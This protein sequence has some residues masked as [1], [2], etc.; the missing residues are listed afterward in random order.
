MIDPGSNGMSDIWEY[1][2]AGSTN[3]PPDVDSDGDGASNQHESIAGTNPL[4]ANS[5]PKIATGFYSGPRFSVTFPA[6]NGVQYQLQSLTSLGATNWLMETG[7]VATGSSMTLLGAADTDSK[8]FRVAV[9]GAGPGS[10]SPPQI[11]VFSHRGPSFTATMSGVAGKYYELQSVASLSSTNWLMETGTVA[12]VDATL[13]LSAS[14]LPGEKFFR[15]AISDMDSDLDGASD[16]EERQIGTDPFAA[17]STGQLDVNGQ[18]L[19][20]SAYALSKLASQN[21]VTIYASE[22]EATQPDAGQTATDLGNFT[23]VRGGLPLNAVTVNLGINGPAPGVAVEGVDHAVLLRPV[24][25]AAGSAAAN[26]QVVPLAHTN[27]LSP[28]VATMKVMGGSGYSV[29]VFSNANVVIYPSPTPTGTGLTA[30]Y[31]DNASS[32]YTNAANFSGT[33]VTQLDPKIDFQ[34]S[35]TT[36]PTPGIATNTYSIRWMGQVQPQYSEPYV[37]IVRT[38]DGSKLWVNDQ[39]IHDDWRNKGASDV[40]SSEITLQAGVRY[41]LKLEYYQNT[42][43]AEARLYWYS[44][45]Q[46]KQIIP[47]ARLY[48]DSVTPAPTAVTS[49]LKLY[50]FLGQPFSNNV[51]AANSPLGYAATGLPPGLGFNSTNGAI[52]GVPA[53]TG[54]FSVSLTASNAVGVGA[55]VVEIDVIEAGSAVSREVWLGVSGTNVADIPVNTPP[56]S[57]EAWGALEGVTD[58]GDNYGER[59]RG[60]LTAPATGNYHFWIAGSDAAELWISND[61]EACNKVRRAWVTPGGTGSQQWNLQAKQ[62]SPWLAMVAGQRYYIEILH[63]AGASTGDNW[64]V[65]WLFDPTGTNSSPSG[66]VPS[67]VLSRHFDVPPAFVPGTLYTANLLAQPG[68][69]SSGVGTAT[70]RVSADETHAVLKYNYSGLSGPITSQ[71]IHSDPYL[72]FPSTILFDIDDAEPEP[73]GSL[74]WLIEP[75]GAL[76]ADDIR[77]IIKEGKTYINL[78]TAAYPAGEIKGNFTLAEGS[79]SF[80]PPPA[81]PA[82]ADDHANASAAARFLIQATFGSTA[83]DIASVQSLG[84]EGW[85]DNQFAMPVTHHLPIVHANVGPDPT[86]PYSGNLTFN[87]WWQQSITAP[88]Q[89]RQRVAFALSEIL[90]VSEQGVLNNRG[91]A[92][93][94]YYDTLLEHSFGNFRDLLE[95]VTLHP[96]MGLYLDMRR[97]D[98]GNILTGT[99]PNENYAREILQ[100]FSIGLY[101]QWPDGTLVMNSEGN[102]VPTYG[103]DEILGF[104]R[105][106]TGWNYYQT[107]Q[108][109]GRLPS[110]WNPSANYTNLMVLVPTHHELGTKLVLDNVVLPQAWGDE[111]DSGSTN[112]DNYG[113]RD[114]ELSHDSIFN[115]ENVGPFIC[116]QLIQRLVT[117]HPTRDYVYRVVQ[118][119]NDNGNGVRGDMQAVIKAILLDYQARSSAAALQPAFGKQ[120][121]PL[122][123]VTAPARAFATPPPVSGTY[124]QTGTQTISVTTGSPHRMNNND[125]P[126]C[127]FTDTSGH[128]APP[129]QRY[130]NVSVTGLNTFNTTAPGL[131]VGTY[132]QSANTITVIN[133]GHA[134]A[135]GNSVHLTFTSGGASNGA[136]VVQSVPSTTNFTVTAADS[137]TRSGSC[138]FPKWTGGG[139]VQ[140]A[141]NVTFSL[142]LEHGLTVGDS[143]YVNF[144]QANAP[145]DGIY[146]VTATNDPI[147]FSIVVTNSANRTQ[148]GQTIFPLVQTLLNRSGNVEV[149][150]NTWQMNAT[151]TGT[152]LSLSQTP[153]NSP[154]VF[155]YYF[156]DYKFPGILASAGL[157][158][159]EFQLTSDTE[160]MLQMNFMTLG[161][162]GNTGN[163][164]GLSSFN[165]GNGAI[166]LDL[167][168]WMTPAYTSNAGIPGLVDE[169]N[170]LLCGG[171][172][173]TNARTTIINYATTLSYTTP[174]ATQMRD[175]V[176]AV[177]HLMISSPEFTIQ[178]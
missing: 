35:A 14:A 51:T 70:L 56:S 129:S 72:S 5:S 171:N 130:V 111:A 26:I 168:P 119:F 22:P 55:S 121:E 127:G 81:P 49:P 174:T 175:R 65:G 156:P 165:N 24:N 103:Q 28:V 153:L 141:T 57:T 115:N 33:N 86:V 89:L 112:Y 79:Q 110:N 84:Y 120:R 7:A 64:A 136:Y 69:V 19:N 145:A 113:P 100:L 155:N 36:E 169:F 66:L 158:T 101:R 18:P 87:T 2:F 77:E 32:T 4:D 138:V 92:L 124:V 73:D 58:F 59:I 12:V 27:L 13:T 140:S 157:T 76:S 148:N 163:T 48:P 104:S 154:T 94:S 116:R 16:W 88:D 31:F 30:Q 107:N 68:A 21:V 176:R 162:L 166:W 1:K 172:L 38:D 106:F 37:F 159:P 67:Y 23:V 10:N 137:A 8:F 41:N 95:D 108:G 99:H 135:A 80:T 39:L 25:L 177:V 11:T 132:S 6:L 75:V 125:D 44:P 78:H 122:L 128:P 131:N 123:R 147:R 117:S 83:S 61:G 43:S 42:G 149:S 134:L 173:S 62:Q 167:G 178:K 150:Y 85:I 161:I 60:Y 74:V 3:L 53:Q 142:T 93:S 15:V 98:K 143:V 29:G 102:L 63:K 46:P 34:W 17:A 96:A 52:S 40:A 144:T 160:A 139:Y 151:D 20:D 82:W 97:N 109:N 152:T 170:T 164:N 126:F 114:L 118:K 45:S 47:T 105:V 90:V 50:A 146:T 133:S 9:I 91:T 54:N 71:H